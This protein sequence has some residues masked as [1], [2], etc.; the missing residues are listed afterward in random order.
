MTTTPSAKTMLELAAQA[1]YDFLQDKSFTPDSDTHRC[2]AIVEQLDAALMLPQQSGA[3][4]VRW[5]HKARGT[6]YTE[7]GRGRFQGTVA[8]MDCGDH[9]PVVL[10]RADAD[11]SLWC[12]T[13]EEFDDG[14]FEPAAPLPTTDTAEGTG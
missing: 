12:R 2:T 8:G 1:A 3:G 4:E 14:R 10:Y 6:T 7:I 13:V 11:G 5:R 9:E